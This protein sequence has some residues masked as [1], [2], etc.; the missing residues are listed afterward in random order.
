MQPGSVWPEYA[1][2]FHIGGNWAPPFHF[3]IT[4]VQQSVHGFVPWLGGKEHRK[5]VE[6]QEVNKHR[7]FA[8]AR[9]PNQSEMLT[10][11]PIEMTGYEYVPWDARRLAGENGVSVARP[12]GP[13]T[14]TEGGQRWDAESAARWER[15]RAVGHC[16]ASVSPPRNDAISWSDT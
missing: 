5:R 14:I 8:R 1:A 11:P 13:Y 4:R 6:R 3:V 15:A 2:R 12:L 9:W 10:H 16:S 7:S